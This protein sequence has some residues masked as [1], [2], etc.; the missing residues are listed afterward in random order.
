MTGER[1]RPPLAAPGVVPGRG[2]VLL[3]AP[4]R[5]PPARAGAVARRS[6]PRR[7]SPAVRAGRAGPASRR[8][9]EADQRSRRVCSLQHRRV[10]GGH[11]D[12]SRWR[13]PRGGGAARH[14]TATCRCGRATRTATTQYRY[15]ELTDVSVTSPSGAPTDISIS[16]FGAYRAD[17]HRQ[18]RRRPSPEPQT[19][20]CG[21]PLAHVVNDIGDGTAEFYYNHHRPLQRATPTSNVTADRHRAGAG[22]PGRPASTA[23][24]LDDTSATR[25]RGRDHARSPSPTSSPSR[26]PASLASY[27]RDAFG[28]LTP[29]LREGY[30]D[31]GSAAASSPG[32]RSRAAVPRRALVG[33]A[34]WCRCSP[35]P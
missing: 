10:R 15:Y 29:D 26:A 24:R 20:S 30:S 14:R 18:R 35:V 4:S 31:G 32:P 21:Y 1:A 7:S 27:P 28:D 19:T 11:R 9:D 22:H 34:C 13:L 16:D 23:P 25:H 5:W 12:A 17:P 3:L 33:S 8:G 6:R 2:V